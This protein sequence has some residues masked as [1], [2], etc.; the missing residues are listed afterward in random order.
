MK[1]VFCG[2]GDFGIPVLRALATSGQEILLVYTQP[3]RPAGRRGKITQTP[4]A[5]TAKELSLDVVEAEDINADEHVAEIAALAPDVLLVIDFGQKIGRPVRSAGKFGAINLHGSLLPELRGAAPVNWGI[6]RGYEKTGVSVIEV[7]DRMDTGA[8]FS[9][10]ATDI[11]PDETADELR[12]RLADMGVEA[13]AETLAL[14]ASDGCEGDRQDD[15]LATKA[16]KLKK[17]DGLIDFSTDSVSVRNLIHGCWPWPG[18][19]TQ[20]VAADG[21]AISVVIARAV[22]I[23]GEHNNRQGSI[24]DDLNVVCGQGLLKILQLK[25]AGKRMMEWR[26][27][28]NGYRVTTGTR[29]ETHVTR[30]SRP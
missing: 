23:E 7:A 13:I 25:P 28:V 3:A 2:S 12:R 16:P 8:I 21:K 17:S 20:F 14:L 15:S 19:Q 18:G 5:L 24:D 1:I 29:F 11:R 10:R 9:R 30:A 27:F 22:A 4:T 26:D 6:I